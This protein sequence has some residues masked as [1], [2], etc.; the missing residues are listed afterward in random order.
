M[1]SQRRAAFA[2]TAFIHR[3]APLLLATA[4]LATIAC[5]SNG[6]GDK[7][8]GPTTTVE[9]NYNLRTV[10]GN[11]LPVE[12]YHG[13][14]F[15]AANT[16]FYNQM[17][18]VVKNGVI[19]LDDTDGWAMTMDVQMTLDAV[20]TQQ[21]LAIMGTYEIDGDDIVLSAFDDE[22]E[23]AGTIKK[24]TISLTMDVGGSKRDKAY[25]FGR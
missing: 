15:D 14:W 3:I 6:G 17:I 4:L 22:T 11:R 20:T 16:R 24:G 12:V 10:D 13:P 1:T 21:T 9:G 5:G 8:T 18:L 2:R 19:N 25:S 7:T 23:L